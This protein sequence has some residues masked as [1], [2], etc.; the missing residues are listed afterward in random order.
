MEDKEC[1]EIFKSLLKNNTKPEE[2][3]KKINIFVELHQKM[4]KEMK[5]EMREEIKMKEN[6]NLI[7]PIVTLR[8]MKYC[9]CLNKN[10]S[11]TARIAAEIS[12]TARF[13]EKKRNDFKEILNKLGN[14]QMNENI[15]K[16]I[17]KG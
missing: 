17:E 9:C 2:Y 6:K 7:D 10:S 16:D 8:N 13:P 12:Y 14:F 4:I 11:I 5:E 3:I 1:E 15:K